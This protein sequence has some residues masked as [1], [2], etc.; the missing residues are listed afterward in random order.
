MGERREESRNIGRQWEEREAD[1]EM[2]GKERR[3]E[4]H[5]DGGER[6]ES[7][8]I[9]RQW[10]EREADAE[11]EGREERGREIVTKL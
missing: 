5:R 1:T 2:E 10:E 3:G 4:R 8:N 11:M 6:E 7:R 9:G